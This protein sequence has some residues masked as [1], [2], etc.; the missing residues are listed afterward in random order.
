MTAMGGVY[1]PARGSTFSLRRNGKGNAQ[2]RTKR[3]KR[4]LKGEETWYLGGRKDFLGAG[5][6]SRERE[7]RGKT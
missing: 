1:A 6:H 7:G 2:G 3:K 5:R 4:K